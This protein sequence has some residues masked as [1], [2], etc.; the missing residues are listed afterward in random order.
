MVCMICFI[1][2]SKTQD[3]LYLALKLSGKNRV[4]LE[5]VITHYSNH[6][7]DSLKL[8][9][10]CFLIEKYLLILKLQLYHF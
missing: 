9:A 4:E 5:K 10:A 2:C 1:A 6:E 7:V 8:K 3:K